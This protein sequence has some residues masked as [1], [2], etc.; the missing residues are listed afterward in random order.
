LLQ[1]HLA[2]ATQYPEL[3]STQTKRQIVEARYKHPEAVLQGKEDSTKARLKPKYVWFAAHAIFTAE[4]IY[5]L[6]KTL[7]TGPW[8]ATVLGLVERHRTYVLHDTFPCKQYSDE[9]IRLLSSD[10]PLLSDYF[11]KEF[12]CKPAQQRIG[13]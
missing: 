11:R 3:S 8:E 6:T 1:D 12:F 10:N 4:R 13:I 2:L 5:N 7:D 9:F